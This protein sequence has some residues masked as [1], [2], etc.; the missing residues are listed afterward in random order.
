MQYLAMLVLLAMPEAALEPG[1][2]KEQSPEGIR[3]SRV[4]TAS[5]AAAW[6]LQDV[7]TIK[8]RHSRLF[9]RYLWVPPWGDT[10]W[11]QTNSF[12]VNAAASQSSVIRLPESAAGGWLI[13]WDLRR[14]APKEAELRWLLIVWDSLA[15]GEPFFHIQLVG[16][17]K[18]CEPHV[19]IDGRTYKSRGHWPAPHCFEAYSLLEQ[20]TRSFTPLLRADDFERRLLSTIEGGRYYHFVGFIQDGRRLNEAQIFAAVGLSVDLSRSVQGTDRVGRFVSDV[21]DK[22][23]TIEIAQ[24]AIGRARITYDIFDE[25]DDPARHPLYNLLKFVDAARGKEI[26]FER[27]NGLHGFVITDGKGTLVDVAPDNLVADHLA[28]RPATRRLFA[29]LSCIRCHAANGGVQ[30]CPNDVKTLLGD[31]GGFDAFDDL[32]DLTRGRFENVD[33]LAGLYAGDFDKRLREIRNDYADAMFQATRGLGVKEACDNLAQRYEDYWNAK[34]TPQRAALEIG[35]QVAEADAPK[36]LSVV[37]KRK[38]VDLEIDA[39]PIG[40]DDPSIAALTKGLS[41][42]RRDFNRV[43]PDAALRAQLFLSK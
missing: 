22:P 34:V 3:V 7:L 33:E 37:L 9:T 12:A 15:I 8:D 24:G 17:T 41:I 6:A 5:D 35:F 21:T 40:F 13:R 25:D 32:G 28:P 16:E 26:I 36:L 11:H 39:T 18:P 14:L 27:A 4:A 43:F 23:R 38:T 10:T 19:H 2:S 29:G 20:E 30:S 1:Q 42:R 31:V